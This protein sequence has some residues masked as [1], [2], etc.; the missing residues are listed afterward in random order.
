[1]P[2][3]FR[4]NILMPALSG[5]NKAQKLSLFRKSIFML[6]SNRLETIVFSI[7]L[8][9]VFVGLLADLHFVDND[10]IFKSKLDALNR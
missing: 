10:P 1:M 5:K 3:K 6:V 8:A 2:N 4:K 9:L 7:M